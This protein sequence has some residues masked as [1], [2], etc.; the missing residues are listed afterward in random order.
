MRAPFQNKTFTRKSVN[1]SHRPILPRTTNSTAPRV[2][3]KRLAKRLATGSCRVR[4]SSPGETNGA[5]ARY[6]FTGYVCR[7]FSTLY[8]DTDS[9]SLLAGNGK[10]VL[11]CA[12][13]RFLPTRILNT[14]FI[15]P[16]SSTISPR[17]ART[18]LRP[19]SYTS[20]STFETK[21][22]LT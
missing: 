12:S 9:K 13:L 16:R 2:V 22:S 19:P 3:V 10:S 1:G 8:R 6:G 18:T 17:I 4:S 20:T 7:L 15:A 5:V 11:W 21:P 14:K